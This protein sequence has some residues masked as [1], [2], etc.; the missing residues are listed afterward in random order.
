M[1]RKKEKNVIFQVNPLSLRNFT[2]YFN[3]IVLTTM[4]FF[5]IGGMIYAYLYTPKFEASGLLKSQPYAQIN[6]ISTNSLKEK[7]DTTPQTMQE[8][9]LINTHS[10]FRKIVDDLHLNLKISQGFGTPWSGLNFFL[11]QDHRW[12]KFLQ[13]SLNNNW[14]RSGQVVAWSRVKIPPALF[15]KKIKL[16]YLGKGHYKLVL[17][18]SVIECDTAKPCVLPGW[19]EL[20]T[21]DHLYIEPNQKLNILIENPDKV[22]EEL[23]SKVKII[24]PN[25]D[26]K[27][28]EQRS[29]LIQNLIQVSFVD[30]NPIFAAAVINKLLKSAVYFSKERKKQESEQ[31]AQL[32][33]I[34][35]KI[36][37]NQ[38]AIANTELAQLKNQHQPM[39]LETEAD[40]LYK[41]LGFIQETLIM[42]Q[43]KE[44]DFRLRMTSQNSQL[45]NVREEIGILTQKEN[46]INNIIKHSPLQAKRIII[47]EGEVSAQLD[48]LKNTVVQQQLLSSLSKIDFSDLQIVEK[49]SIPVTQIDY[50]RLELILMFAII[51]LILGYIIATAI[52]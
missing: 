9:D 12:K 42:L 28:G 47:L 35:Q 34:Q 11:N 8:M 24:I 1:T 23:R 3:F 10:L 30:Q 13:T 14:S 6:D 39:T 37:Y 43:Q 20:W 5:V 36:I 40:Y 19:G 38:L 7:R 2:S 22:T 29:P 18:D 17:P 31:A 4:L 50:S 48:L 27:Q 45:R 33:K 32:L 25:E 26:N 15:G 46:K 41:R 51:G 21:V 16:H 49:A 52:V 44:Q